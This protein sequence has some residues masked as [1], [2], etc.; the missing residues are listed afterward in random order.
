[1]Y[2]ITSGIQIN[3]TSIFFK[4]LFEMVQKKISTGF[5]VQISNLLKDVGFHSTEDMDV[6]SNTMLDAENV[7][8]LRLKPFVPKFIVA[9]K[10]IGMEQE[11]A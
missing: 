5:A 4:T 9:K 8:A 7:V 2:S 10:E 1:M 11:K 6:T 3:C